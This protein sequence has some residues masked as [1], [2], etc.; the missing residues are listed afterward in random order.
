MLSRA[1]VGSQLMIPY[2]PELARTAQNRPSHRAIMQ[3]IFMGETKQGVYYLIRYK[4][5]PMFL[6]LLL[7]AQSCKR[8]QPHLYG[9]QKLGHV[10]L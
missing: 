6:L 1:Q 9:K 2:R 4:N 10:S 7:S 5:L 8:G 3:C